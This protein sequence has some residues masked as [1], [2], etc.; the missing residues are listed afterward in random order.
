[1]IYVTSDTHFNHGLTSEGFN[2]ERGILAYCDRGFE[3]S[4][5]GL[6]E[7]N[8][9]LIQ[10][11]NKVVG[12]T[13]TVIHA[14]DFALGQKIHHAG[15]VSRL[16][17]YK[18]I[19]RGNHDPTVKKLLEDGWDE[20][21]NQFFIQWKQYRIWVAHVPS[22]NAIDHVEGRELKRP[23]PTES[24]DIELCGHV[25]ESFLFAENGAMNVGVD[26]WDMAPIHIDQAIGTWHSWKSGA[27]RG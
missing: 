9:T 27:L 13:D 11:W 6:E 23:D 5:R 16:N 3:N 2:P 18:I 20:V 26:R 12:P 25:H 15:F 24:Y 21:Y 17:G 19:T 7:M 8:E 22:D 10:N 14:G 1:M 4:L